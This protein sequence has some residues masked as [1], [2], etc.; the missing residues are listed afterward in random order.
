[1]VGVAPN[2]WNL[3]YMID[4]SDASSKNDKKTLRYTQGRRL[5]QMKKG[6]LGKM[7]DNKKAMQAGERTV[8]NP[9]S[10]G[11]HTM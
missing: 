7:E 8:G 4:K 3:L 11:V 2:M 9:R 1:M 10:A 6:K 5:Q